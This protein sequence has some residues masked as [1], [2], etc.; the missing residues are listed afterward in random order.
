MLISALLFAGWLGLIVAGARLAARDF[1]SWWVVPGA[2]LLLV[3]VAV[4]PRLGRLRDGVVTVDR[5]RAPALFAVV[6]RVAAEV[7][8]PPPHQLVVVPEFN[9]FSAVVGL[10]RRR[11]LG[12]GLPLWAA[13][14]PQ[15][16]VALLA[17]ELGH[18]VNGDPR[19]GLVTQPAYATLAALAELTR[20]GVGA[21]DGVMVQLARPLQAALS[22]AFRFAQLAVVM[23]GQRDAQRAEY[24]AD[25]VSARVAGTAASLSMLDALLCGEPIGFGLCRA[26]RTRWQRAGG[27][28][29]RGAR[30]EAVPPDGGADEWRA[31]A[32]LARTEL[33][34]TLAVRRQLS[35]R[36]GVS[37]FGGHPATGLRIRRLA[38]LRQLPAV[39]AHSEAEAA[40]VD[41]EL[42]DHYRRIGRDLAL[43]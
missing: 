18:F 14:T 7:G 10:R 6:D 4:R 15:E 21:A 2:V 8:T 38:A 22:G 28:R 17:H 11:V 34:P 30:V 32:A 25:V 43:T 20:P 9:A 27:G 41:A 24:H 35:I 31:A 26:A 29:A 13:L 5:G 40:R 33:A 39:V 16:R 37:L 42:A 1:P 36:D 3:A 12:L 23:I 19:R